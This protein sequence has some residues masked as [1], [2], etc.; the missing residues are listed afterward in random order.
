MD[1]DRL[2][3]GKT[4]KEVGEEKEGDGN[5]ETIQETREDK[6]ALGN[7]I[8]DDLLNQTIRDYEEELSNGELEYEKLVDRT[9]EELEAIEKGEELDKDA[10]SEGTNEYSNDYVELENEED[11][12]DDDEDDYNSEED[13]YNSQEDDY[14]SEEDDYYNE[15]DDYYNGEDDGADDFNNDFNEKEP[16]SL[17]ESDIADDSFEDLSVRD[18]E[19]G[20]DSYNSSDF[21]ANEMVSM[22]KIETLRQSI[23]LKVAFFEVK[24][25]EIKDQINK[26]STFLNYIELNKKVNDTIDEIFQNENASYCFECLED[27]LEKIKNN[28]FDWFYDKKTLDPVFEI[29]AFFDKF[30]QDKN[31]KFMDFKRIRDLLPIET[32]QVYFSMPFTVVDEDLLIYGRIIEFQSLM[33]SVFYKVYLKSF[34]AFQ[35]RIDAQEINII[36]PFMRNSIRKSNIKFF[37][38]NFWDVDGFEIYSFINHLIDSYVLARLPKWNIENGSPLVVHL[39][40]IIRFLFDYGLISLEFCSPLLNRLYLISESLS[41]LEETHQHIDKSEVNLKKCR[42]EFLVC[43]KNVSEIL[44]HVYILYSDFAFENTLD[45]IKTC[46]DEQRFFKNFLFDRKIDY[47]FFC[48]ILIKYLSSYIKLDEVIRSEEIDKIMTMLFDFLGDFNDDPFNHSLDL[49]KNSYYEYFLNIK[50][51]NMKMLKSF[52]KPADEIMTRVMAFIDQLKVRRDSDNLYNDFI[53][54]LSHIEVSIGMTCSDINFCLELTRKSF[55]ST[56]LSLLDSFD[57]AHTDLKLVDRMLIVLISILKNN[58]PGQ[59]ELLRGKSFIYFINLIEKYDLSSLIFLKEVFEQDSFLLFFSQDI[60]MLYLRLYTN[61]LE[62]IA[63]K[64]ADLEENYE[65]VRDDVDFCHEVGTLFFYNSYFETILE[66]YNIKLNRRKRY[67]LL[68]SHELGFFLIENVLSKLQQYDFLDNYKDMHL[69]TTLTSFKLQQRELIE[70]LM[71]E[72]DPKRLLFQLYY[73]FLKLYNKACFKLFTHDLYND[74]TY[75][76]NNGDI[77]KMNF[78]YPESILLRLEFIKLYERFFIFFP[79]NLVDGRVH[80]NSYG[81]LFIGEN[82]IPANY[83]AIGKFILNEFDWFSKFTQQH[84]D[85]DDDLVKNIRTY[86]FK[87]LLSMVYKFLKGIMVHISKIETMDRIIELKCQVDLVIDELIMKFPIFKR[88]V[89]GNS[90]IENVGM[91]LYKKK[92]FEKAVQQISELNNKEERTN[93]DLKDMRIQLIDGIMRINKLYENT[94]FVFIINRYRR[95]G[96]VNESNVLGKGKD[97]E[98]DVS[99]NLAMF[100]SMLGSKIN[101][102][103]TLEMVKLKYIQTKRKYQNDT[104]NNQFFTVLH[105]FKDNRKNLRNILWFFINQFNELEFLIQ[106]RKVHNFYLCNNKFFSDIIILDNLIS[107]NPQVRKEF[108]NIC[109]S[110]SPEKRQF[111]FDKLWG[112]FFSLYI[113]VVFKT[114][115]DDEWNI[116][117]GY[118]TLLSKLLQN[119]NDQNS[120]RFKS[121][122]NDLSKVRG[123]MSYFTLLNMD[124]DNYSIFFENYIL[125]ETLG[126]FSN[127]WLNTE[128]TLGPSD[129][130]EMFPIFIRMFSMVSEYITGP[131]EANQLQIYRFRIDIWYGIINRIIDNVDSQFYEVKLACLNYISAL[132]EGLNNDIVLFLASNFQVDKLFLLIVRLT[133]KLYIRQTLIEKVKWEKKTKVDLLKA[134]FT[135]LLKSYKKDEFAG[136]NERIMKMTSSEITEKQEKEYQINHFRELFF[137]Y[138]SFSESFSNHVLLKIVVTTFVLIVNMSYKIKFFEFFLKDKEK[139]NSRYMHYKKRKDPKEVEKMII[140]RFLR[141]IT[142]DIEIVHSDKKAKKLQRLFFMVPPLC[143]FMT[144]NMKKRFLDSINYDSTYNKHIDLFDSIE[145][146]MMEMQAHKNYYQRYKQLY[147]FTTNGFFQNN[148]IALYVFS[149]VLNSMMLYY[150][151]S[152]AETVGEALYGA[153]SL[154]VISDEGTV[155]FIIMGII[156]TVYSAALSIAWLFLKYQL[157]VDI[158]VHKIIMTG[159]R[160]RKRDRFR[161]YLFEC[162]FFHPRFVPFIFHFIFTL[163]GLLTGEWFFYTLNLFLI[164]NLF[165]TINYIMKSI[166]VHYGKL[167]VIFLLTLLTMFGYAFLLFLNFSHELHEDYVGICDNFVDCFL[168]SVNHGFRLGGGIAEGMNLKADLATDH[169]H[170]FSRF[171]F[172]LTYFIFIKMIFLNLIAGIIIDTFSELRDSLTKKNYDVNN[173]CFICG[174]TRWQ[175]E[176]DGVL[177]SKHIVDDHSVWVYIYYMVRLRTVDS[178]SFTGI[179]QYVNDKTNQDDSSWLPKNIYL[180]PNTN[181]LDL[182]TNEYG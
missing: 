47:Y 62:A 135:I 131:H 39:L 157:E 59:S 166:F 127:F 74:T 160:L 156:I 167:L 112:T 146:T 18:D 114:F 159:R 69:N 50:Q 32:F 65:L 134:Q 63:N 147:Y 49:I 119:F 169:A 31:I 54:M 155:L 86:I 45:D 128:P 3:S 1:K 105:S 145:P 20:S 182:K 24:A 116:F 162:L 23:N 91:E 109:E 70:A 11:D 44:I 113:I 19:Y 14:N 85:K 55:I 8:Y 4:S 36:D 181:F 78:T 99:S 175:L 170:F 82:Y 164:T 101:K 95:D 102:I 89:N 151:V 34:M 142:V 163:L 57:E 122:F 37:W 93:E 124:Q 111:L 25:E 153:V 88:M 125:L 168:N 76:F 77:E 143:F 158:R 106:D 171:F 80:A 100:K 53:R 27:H 136:E 75:S 17:V 61:K 103:K 138:T 144:R 29:F 26:D 43:R 2:G 179:E 30:Y 149:L 94:E 41:S 180:K 38:D 51:G 58:Y 137:M 42:Q 52:T 121:F 64:I 118:F 60:F 12:N 140:Y 72:Q 84:N 68:L 161:I 81:N 90:V 73:S 133:K 35:P 148:Q 7:R 71:I 9:F 141:S 177:F 173:I 108:L 110:M 165:G 48:S 107:R 154:K 176:K 104:K 46:I 123:A 66:N 150:L 15:E 21:I 33:L 6:E 97:Y 178:S 56:W 117:F 28:L 79:N 40:A 120:M 22:R 16:D 67:D 132:L 92:V 115:M 5:V 83:N 130:P 13:D 152:D 172:D 98:N 129:R 10:F 126:N 174:M 96:N 87:G 139:Q